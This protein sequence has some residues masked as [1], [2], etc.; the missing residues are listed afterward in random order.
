MSPASYLT[1]PPRVAAPIVAPKVTIARMW[2][3]AI[4]A[5]LIVAAL[6]GIAAFALLAAR[7]R[8][9]WRDVKDARREAVRR[10]DELATRAEAA[11]EK[12]AATGETAEL[13]ESLQHLRVS[14]AQLAA[15][16]AAIDE[17]QDAVGRVI[18]YLPRG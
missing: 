11:T 18:S 13:Q 10:L 5:A 1:A 4:W 16:R 8:S 7:A 3:W 17:S 12:I 15:L 6:A 2:D 9:A 14:L